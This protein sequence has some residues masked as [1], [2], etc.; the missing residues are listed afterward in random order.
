MAR[1]ISL[2]AIGA[3]CLGLVGCGAPVMAP[4]LAATSLV[5]T[6]GANMSDDDV[7]KLVRL[8]SEEPGQSGVTIDPAKL[9][10]ANQALVKDKAAREKAYPTSD[11]IIERLFG[12][13]G[14]VDAIPRLSAQDMQVFKSKLQPGDVIQC[15]N[16]GSFIH[17]V[18][19]VGQDVIIH[20][21]AENM[22]GKKMIGVIKET[23][24]DY[25]ARVERDQVVVLRPKWSPAQLKT[26]VTYAET[27]VGK[28]YDSLFLTESADRFYCTELV[29]QTLTAAKVARIQPRMVK[30]AWPVVMNEEIRRSP[31]LKVVYT[32][33]HD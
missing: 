4:M 20:A 32:K 22:R 27:Q 3:L 23:L 17:G 21:L 25:F 6:Q 14:K 11:K 16:D 28:G 33:N 12:R 9:R 24:T 5:D 30:D 8:L 10:K 18:F 15:G 19:Y 29:Y 31:D 2:A 13:P 1:R 7:F 26:A